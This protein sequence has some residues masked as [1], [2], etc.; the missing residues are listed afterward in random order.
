MKYLSITRR[1]SLFFAGMFALA[2]VLSHFVFTKYEAS[3]RHHHETLAAQ[4]VR[5]VSSELNLLLGEIRR[6]TG[7]FVRHNSELLL[8]MSRNPGDE[9]IY[10]RVNKRQILK[11]SCYMTILEKKSDHFA[12]EIYNRK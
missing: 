11:V 1:A 9:E 10:N 12:Y 6:S 5:A 8:Q 7:L 3:F 4:S 2:V